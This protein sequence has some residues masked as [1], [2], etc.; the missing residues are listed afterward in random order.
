[1]QG[2]NH[3][4]LYVNSTLASSEVNIT[5][6]WEDAA[7]LDNYGIGNDYGDTGSYCDGIMSNFF[8]TSPNT[9]QISTMLGVGPRYMPRETITP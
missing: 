3:F 6:A 9:P 5:A 1:M 8:V 2:A 7:A 4:A